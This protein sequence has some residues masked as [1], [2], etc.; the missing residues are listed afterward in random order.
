MARLPWKARGGCSI[1]IRRISS[2]GN[3]NRELKS[4][5]L[6]TIVV[7]AAWAETVCHR[8]QKEY[9]QEF[10]EP[11]L[12]GRLREGQLAFTLMRAMSLV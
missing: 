12:L 9:S 5:L 1:A 3:S 7:V 10:L 4:V 11:E 6:P 2:L 8:L